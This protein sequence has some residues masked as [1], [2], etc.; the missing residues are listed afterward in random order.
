MVIFT[1]VTA[2]SGF[3]LPIPWEQ[4]IATIVYFAYGPN[5]QTIKF[6]EIERQR[7]KQV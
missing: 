2:I 1:V 6:L 7:A 3:R 5:I 4:N